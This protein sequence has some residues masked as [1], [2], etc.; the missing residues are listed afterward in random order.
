MEATVLERAGQKHHGKAATVL[1]LD[2]LALAVP[3]LAAPALAGQKHGQ[4]PAV[5]RHVAQ[6]RGVDELRQRLVVVDG[7]EVLDEAWK[8]I[9]S[10]TMGTGN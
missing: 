3:A 9:S 8:V 5:L 1:A 10:W 7:P 2:V 6:K 4:E